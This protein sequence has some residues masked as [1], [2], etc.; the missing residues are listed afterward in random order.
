MIIL[1]LKKNDFKNFFLH[2]FL[3]QEWPFIKGGDAFNAPSFSISVEMFFISLFLSFLSNFQKN[4]LQTIIVAT[5][6]LILYFFESN[7]NL[8]L[9]FFFY[10]GVIYYL[11]KIIFRY[12]NQNKKKFFYLNQY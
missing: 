5:I 12:L 7:L 10:G 1:F 3:I 11:I 9:F 4:L 2:I 8:G 6:T